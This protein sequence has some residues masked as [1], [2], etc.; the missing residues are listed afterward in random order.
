MQRETSSVLL[1]SLQASTRLL[2]ALVNIASVANREKSL[3]Y[4]IPSF[5][6]IMHA[7]ESSFC[8][9]EMEQY[10]CFKQVVILQS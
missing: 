2:S 7:N 5:D 4:Y 6:I 3:A 1:A 8:M 9:Y 10:N